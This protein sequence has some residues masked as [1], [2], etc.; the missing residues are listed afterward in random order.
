M[1]DN[2]CD[3]MWRKEDAAKISR[4]RMNDPPQT[5]HEETDLESNGMDHNDGSHGSDCHD[6]LWNGAEWGKRDGRKEGCHGVC[7]PGG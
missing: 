2:F 3:G 5:M 1:I 4:G 6:R 7:R